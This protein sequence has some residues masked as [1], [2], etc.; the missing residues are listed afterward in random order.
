MTD[1]SASRFRELH[2]PGRLLILPNAWDAASAR[3]IEDCGSEAIATT[4]AVLA[5][6][7]GYPDGNAMPGH[8]LVAAATAIA[9]VIRVPLT[10]DVEAGYSSDP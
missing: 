8:V 7:E 6:A 9:R 1:R 3:L 5:W 2:A 10:V 4:S